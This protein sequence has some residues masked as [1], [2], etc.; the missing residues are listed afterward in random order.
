M[1]P[2]RLV[3]QRSFLPESLLMHGAVKLVKIINA[4]KPSKCH[5]IGSFPLGSSPGSA[6][7]KALLS[8]D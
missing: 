4:W 8:I 7:G 1:V 5:S 2:Q 6:S 3:S